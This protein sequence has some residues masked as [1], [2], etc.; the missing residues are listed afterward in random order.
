[1][2]KVGNSK[3]QAS[4]SLPMELPMFSSDEEQSEYEFETMKDYESDTDRDLNP[5]YGN[6][7]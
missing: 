6:Q 4:K 3:N 2:L 7:V 5:N 1:M